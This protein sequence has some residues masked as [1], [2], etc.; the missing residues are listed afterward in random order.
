M[1]PGRLSPRSEFTPVVSHSS[2]FVYMISPQN[3]MPAQVTQAL[4]HPGSCSGT[5]ISLR[6]KIL[7]RYHVNAK[8]SPFSVWNRSAGRPFSS[9][10]PV[11]SWS[12]GLK[13][14]WHPVVHV[15]KL[16]TSLL[17]LKTDFYPSR[18]HWG[19]NI[20]PELSPES[21]FFGMFWKCTTSL[22][23]GSLIIWS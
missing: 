13:N 6:Y 2:I 11:I 7:Q 22:N 9:P 8:R 20:L 17:M 3:V 10:E 18:L 5:R 23:L 16:Q 19:K 15:Q 1:T 12:R 21:G 4:V 14:F